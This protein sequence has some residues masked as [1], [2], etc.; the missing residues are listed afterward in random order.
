VAPI[1]PIR[2]PI[3]PP[4]RPPIRPPIQPIVVPTEASA[5]TDELAAVV[6]AM[7]DAGHSPAAIDAWLYQLLGAAPSPTQG[8]TPEEAAALEQAIL[9]GEDLDL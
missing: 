1:Q 8:I 9:A 2:P 3:Q 4:I 6:Q 7:L 5:Q